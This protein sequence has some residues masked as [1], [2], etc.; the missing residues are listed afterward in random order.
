MAIWTIWTNWGSLDSLE[1]VRNSTWN[2]EHSAREECPGSPIA[3]NF[4]ERI[5]WKTNIRAKKPSVF[6]TISK[7]AY[8]TAIA[9]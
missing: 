8:P 9:N 3:V 6:S 7:M 2:I 5:D 1:S 4:C